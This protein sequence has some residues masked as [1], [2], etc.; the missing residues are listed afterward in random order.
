MTIGQGTKLPRIYVTWPHQVSIGSHCRIEHGVYFHYDGVYQHGPSIVIGNNSFIGNFCEFNVR[1]KVTIGQN[2]LIAAN[3]RLIDHDHNIEGSGKL[4]PKAGKEGEIIVE[5]HVWIGAGV[6]V[7]KNVHIGHG[8]VVGA[9][10]VVT[11][12]VPPNQIWG[13]VPARKIGDRSSFSK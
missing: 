1:R 11:K 7:L 3:C 12:D 9:N 2:C 13:G 5:D 6:C 8:A 10:A 4:P